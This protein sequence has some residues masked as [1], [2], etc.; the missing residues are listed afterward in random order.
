M[1]GEI[2]FTIMLANDG[3]VNA[4]EVRLT[5]TAYDGVLLLHTLSEREKQERERSFLLPKPPNAPRG[6]YVSPTLGHR[7]SQAPLGNFSNAIAP[8][9]LG[10]RPR[11]RNSFYFADE[12]PEA[13]QLT[14]EAFPHQDDPY[15]LEFR[16]VLANKERLGRAPRLRIQLQASNLRKPIEKF[17]SVSVTFTQ[18]DFLELD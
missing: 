6:C 13:L 17:V 11:Q 9:S 3:F 7:L 5:I 2:P 16:A 1:H 8:G 10:P 15:R 18:G 14:C 4:E 12:S